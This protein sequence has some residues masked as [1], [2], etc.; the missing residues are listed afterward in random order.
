[1]GPLRPTLLAGCVLLVAS[2]PAFAQ[3]A[4]APDDAALIASAESAAP[5]A[6]A[7]GATIHGF[8]ASGQ[9][10]TLREG[11][12]GWWCM[13]DNPT[14]PGPDPM[15]G[16]ANAMD[17]AMAWM[18]KAAPPQGKVGFIVL[19]TATCYTIATACGAFFDSRRA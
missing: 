12:N 5:A 3:D 16:D 8:D 14:T 15:C 17:W 1:M 4:P 18:S 2:S 11:T 7:T 10:V 13:P 6:V 19:R 9:M